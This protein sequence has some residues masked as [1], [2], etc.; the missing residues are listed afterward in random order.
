MIQDEVE[1]IE[2]FCPFC[3]TEKDSLT[4]KCVCVCVCVWGGGGGGPCISQI[5]VMY[6]DFIT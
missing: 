2:W 1:N 5:P 6:G 3:C 4:I